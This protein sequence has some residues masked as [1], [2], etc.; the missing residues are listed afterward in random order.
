MIRELTVADELELQNLPLHIQEII[1]LKIREA[2]KSHENEIQMDKDEEYECGYED[3]YSEG[4]REGFIDGE[5]G[6]R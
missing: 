3:G 1:E 4:Y 6:V 2:I 5:D